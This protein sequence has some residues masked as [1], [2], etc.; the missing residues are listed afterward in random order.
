MKK[1]I[2]FVLDK[3]SFITPLFLAFIIPI[4]PKSYGFFIALLALEI[5]IKFKP[6]NIK[7]IAENLS[8]KKTCFWLCL[9][10]IFHLI[11][12]WNTSNFKFAWMDIGMKISFVLFPLLFV[13]SKVEVS[14]MKLFKAFSLGALFAIVLNY[15]I[16]IYLFLYSYDKN[17]FLESELSHFMHRGYWAIY[18]LIAFN[19]FM[20]NLMNKTP[21]ILFNVVSA[22]V[23]FLTLLLL[24]SKTALLLLIISLLCWLFKYMVTYKVYIKTGLLILG[25]TFFSY[26]FVEYNP[27]LK[28]RVIEAYRAFDRYDSYDKQGET[29]SSVSRVLMWESSLDLIKE[30]FFWGVGTGDIKDELKKKNLEKNYI[31]LAEK[32]LNSHNQF[33]NTHLA[34][35]IFGSISLFLMFFISFVYYTQ[36]D[37]FLIRIILF[38]LFGAMLTESFLEI[39][40]GIVPISFL[41]TVLTVTQKKNDIE[42][43]YF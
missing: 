37:V 5:L 1:G 18:L 17:Q 15:S 12:L 3:N 8:W 25:L 10:F 30:N 31:G 34:L 28:N 7:Q 26:S 32:N 24:L 29:E 14:L 9:F 20:K 2:K 36:P 11:G 4:F 13:I 39:Q 41:L 42:K 35:G 21:L 38:I 19:I 27:S 43:V 23:I 40:A 22:I 33:L 6:N 16:S